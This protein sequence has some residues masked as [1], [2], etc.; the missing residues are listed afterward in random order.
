LKYFKRKAIMSIVFLFCGV[1]VLF[2]GLLRLT[3]HNYFSAIF[4]ILVALVFLFDA[5]VY[6]RPYLGLGEEKL[7]VNNG[8][9]KLEILLIDVISISEKNKRLIITF[10]QGSATMNLKLVL[11]QLRKNDKEQFI[12][13]L[14]SKLEAK[15]CEQ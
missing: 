5:Y 1:M 4:Q 2:S 15:F 3:L 8:R 10:R 6:N 7:V 14:K 11:S 12:N 13:D 9:S